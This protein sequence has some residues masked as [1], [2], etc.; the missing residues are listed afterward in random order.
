[1]EQVAKRN[2]ML[3]C[4]HRGSEDRLV[5][6]H[7]DA[8]ADRRCSG[9]GSCAHCVNEEPPISRP[10]CRRHHML[11]RT[12]WH[13]GMS[14]RL[15]TASPAACALCERMGAC[16]VFP[17]NALQPQPQAPRCAISHPA[18][19]PMACATCVCWRR[20]IGRTVVTDGRVR[21]WLGRQ[22]ERC[23]KEPLAAVGLPL[24]T[25]MGLLRVS[26]HMG[27]LRVSAHRRNS[28]Y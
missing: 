6:G 5:S 7:G 22:R 16:R 18:R 24:S 8:F 28:V 25:H 14:R 27:L 15:C 17:R 9:D 11:C 3:Q 19:Y 4:L 10:T 23:T 2:D 26:T 12:R 13:K 20:K 21:V 1:V